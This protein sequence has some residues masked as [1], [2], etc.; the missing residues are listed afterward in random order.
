MKNAH[1]EMD[2]SFLCISEMGNL[3]F[4][5]KLRERMEEIVC[6]IKE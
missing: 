5:Q 4:D 2:F 1:Y 3:N 6:L